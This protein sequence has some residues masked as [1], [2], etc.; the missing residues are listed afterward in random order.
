M[1][2]QLLCLKG[3]D[4]ALLEQHSRE[5]VRARIRAGALEHGFAELMC[6]AQCGQRKGREGEIYDGFFIA[7][8]DRL[9]RVD[10]HECSAAPRWW[11]TARPN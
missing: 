7:D 1:L 8:H 5:C 6:E 11:S 4:N 9:D 10:L 3:I 2:A